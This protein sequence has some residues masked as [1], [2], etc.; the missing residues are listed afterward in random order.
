MNRVAMGLAALAA[1]TVAVAGCGSSGSS[2]TDNPV[3]QQSSTST[4]AIAGC[5]PGTMQTKKSNTLSF[6]VDKPAYAPW[7]VNND[8]TNGKGYED[9]LS[10]AIAKELGFDSAHVVWVREGFHQAI[11]PAPHPFDLYLDQFSIRPTRAK[12]VDFSAPYFD[13][14]QAVV[15]L[16]SSNAAS[17]T[18]LAGLK[19][20]KLG[21]Q[22]GSTSETAI[23]DVVHP[24]QQPANYN[25]N[26]LA[27]QALKNGQIDGLVVD[28]PTAYYITTSGQVPN[29]LIVGQLPAAGG[30]PEQFGALLDKGSSLTS[31]VSKAINA[32]RSDGSL[33]RLQDKWVAH[34]GK[35][36]VLQ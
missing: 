34:V 22:L 17:V 32:L 26:P 28:L 11:S 30:T 14:S 20:L 9:A 13:V 36:P 35:A 10:Y 4:S 25:T 15:A 16:K 12:A 7:Y 31:C 1:T 24:S 6:G 19:S 5:N 3:V 2:T 23:T 29:S 21:A 18:T 8:P 27:V 33:T